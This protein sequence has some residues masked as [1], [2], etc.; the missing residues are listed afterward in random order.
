[1]GTFRNTSTN[2]QV[3]VDDSKDDRYTSGWEPAS[4]DAPAS[5]DKTDEGYG[6]KTVAELK[7][8]IAKRN[9]G[10][11]EEDRV[12]DDGLKA[13]LVAALEADDNK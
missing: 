3:T 12:S 7:E 5:S 10:R 6:S 8:E 13:D 2:V 11:G 4:S 9:E 1:M